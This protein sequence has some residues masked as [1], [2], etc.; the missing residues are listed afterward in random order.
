MTSKTAYANLFCLLLTIGAGFV[1]ATENGKLLGTS[2]VMSVEGAA[3][4][5]IIPWATLNGY[6]T[7]EEIG[8]SLASSTAHVDDYSLQVHGVSINIKDRLELSLAH[9]DFY[10]DALA[11][12]IR[13]N[14]IGLKVRITGDLVYD[15]LP[16][17]SAGMQYKT[18]VDDDVAKLLGAEDT[19]G[20]DLYVSMA[21]AWINGP[22]HR[23][24]FAN[25]NLRYTEANELGLL[26]YGGPE[27]NSRLLFEAATGVFVTKGIALGLEYRQKRNHLSSVKEDSWADIFIAWFPSKAFS[28]TAA[29]LDL[30]EIA[31]QESQQGAY[32]SLQASF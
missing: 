4:G 7:R 20:T 18:L 15:A 3:G 8:V 21:K 27:S 9:Q 26:G 6:A 23:T 11:Q 30:G 16:L 10:S 19:S 17:I 24:A 5:G 25:A 14:I 2:G 31:G 1:N 32:L 22:F 28:V 13:Q 12:S 29:Y